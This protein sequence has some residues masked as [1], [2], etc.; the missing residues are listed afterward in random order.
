MKLGDIKF[1]IYLSGPW[2]LELMKL[3]SSFTQPLQGSLWGLEQSRAQGAME[4]G[5]NRYHAILMCFLLNVTVPFS[6]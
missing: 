3:D 1:L 6:T 2:A 5:S 4:V